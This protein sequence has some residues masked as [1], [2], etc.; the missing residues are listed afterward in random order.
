MR[1]PENSPRLDKDALELLRAFCAHEV[2]FLLVGAHALG[3]Y[4]P[5]RAT[6]DLDL[7]VAPEQRNAERVWAAL[8]EF[9]AP[10]DQLTRKDLVTPGVVFQMGQPP[11]RI[12]LM[13][14]LTGVTFEECWT[15]RGTVRLEGLEIPVISRTALVRNKRATG[16]AKDLLDLALLG[17]PDLNR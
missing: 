6:G 17:E 11:H 14:E 2:R 12:D 13:T 15:G 7:L 4:G 3:F 1:S 5:P 9:G 8:S 16:R 10:L